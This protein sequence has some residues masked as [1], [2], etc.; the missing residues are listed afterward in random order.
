MAYGNHE[1]PS[2]EDMGFPKLNVVVHEHCCVK[3][4]KKRLS[5]LF[6]LGSFLRA[7][8]HA[9]IPLEPF[10]TDLRFPDEA[11]GSYHTLAG[12]VLTQIGP[13]TE[14]FR[15]FRMEWLRV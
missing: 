15:S 6:Q 13:H 9:S 2:H 3:H 5:G 1:A 8:Q 12:F 7:N 11:T 14:R 4:D 10:G